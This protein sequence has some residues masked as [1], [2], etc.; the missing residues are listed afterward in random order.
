MRFI[1]VMIFLLGFISLMG[2][3]A[4]VRKFTRKPKKSTI[5]EVP[6]LFPEE[7]SAADISREER[8]REYFVFWKA[9]Q[10]ELITAL[11]SPASHKKR[12]DCIKE[13][14]KNLEEI[15]PFLFGQRQKQLDDYLEKLRHLENE[16]GKD[17]YDNK[18]TIHK[19]R[20]QT[21]KRNILRDFSYPKVRDFL[22]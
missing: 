6:V 12:K 7:Y 19:N 9:W 1:L 3:E 8:Y 20:A 13:A 4:F 22:R 18:L 10:D 14:V 5:E 17:I 21:L 2:C 15:R 11:D 16:I